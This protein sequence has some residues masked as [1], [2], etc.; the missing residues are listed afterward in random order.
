LISLPLRLGANPILIPPPV[1]TFIEPA[2]SDP[3]CIPPQEF[4]LMQKAL[5]RKSTKGFAA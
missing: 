4:E 3:A 2:N 1:K 5:G